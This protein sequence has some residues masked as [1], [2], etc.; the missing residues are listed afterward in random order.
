MAIPAQLT[1]GRL[2]QVRA[3]ADPLRL[4]LV[5][6]LVAGEL[7]V[8][9]MARAVGAPATRLYHHVELLRDAGLIVVT[10]TIRRRGAEERFYRAAAR[11]YVIN[12]NLLTMTP[13]RERSAANLIELARSVLGGTLND[14]VQGLRRGRV[15][16]GKRGRGLILEG[17]TLRLTAAGFEALARELPAWLDRFAERHRAPGRADYRV[18]LTA[19]PLDPA[20][21]R[22]PARAGA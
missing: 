11:N 19:F 7:S 4:R 14:L 8:A 12:R 17:R 18:V 1:L 21:R 6:A 10:R 15:A 22:P 5:Q 13:D 9:G 16:V 20:T 2:D 3:L